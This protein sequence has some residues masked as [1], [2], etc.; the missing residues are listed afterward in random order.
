MIELVV[1]KQKQI[2]MPA[3]QESIVEAC[4]KAEQKGYN[5]GYTEGKEDGYSTGYD[6]GSAEGYKEGKE[7]G[8]ELGKNEAINTYLS[9]NITELTIP[10]GDATFIE[11]Y[12]FYNQKKNKKITIEDGIVD[13]KDSAFENNTSLVELN[14]PDSVESIGFQSF[15]SCWNL[16]R[17][18]DLVLPKNLKTLAN[19]AF[20]Y[21][22]QQKDLYIPASVETI[23]SH[24]FAETPRS[25]ITFGGI[26]KTISP[27][28]FYNCT[29]VTDIY[30]PWDE[31]AVSGAP[32]AAKNA[33]IHYATVGNGFDILKYV[34]G[35]NSFEYVNGIYEIVSVSYNASK[36]YYTCTMGWNAPE[37]QIECNGDDLSEWIVKGN[38]IFVRSTDDTN[39]YGT[40]YI[41]E[42]VVYKGMGD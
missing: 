1:N 9:Q 34:E 10:K 11:K 42:A 6:E 18:N 33:T 19:H 13:I 3:P 27:N 20:S 26:P 12:A 2:E 29:K 31:G 8:L 23:G 32:W 24:T 28:A 21:C 35:W 22:N 25:T 7:A 37:L 38:N 16:G 39:E 40:Y 4:E 15:R 36:D 30:C 14:L 5:N 41:A 17:V